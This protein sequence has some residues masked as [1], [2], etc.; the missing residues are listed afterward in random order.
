MIKEQGGSVRTYDG[1]TLSLNR[2]RSVFFNDT[3]FAMTCPDI[4]MDVFLRDLQR[5]G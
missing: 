4:D 2:A 3:G 5:L 1:E